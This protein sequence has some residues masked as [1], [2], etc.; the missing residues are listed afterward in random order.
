MMREFVAAAVGAG[1]LQSTV[2]GITRTVIPRTAIC[3]EVMERW[4]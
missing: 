4:N 3:P 2:A 1:A